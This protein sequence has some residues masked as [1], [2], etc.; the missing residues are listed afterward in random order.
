MRFYSYSNFLPSVLPCVWFET[1]WPLYI[2][3][4]VCAASWTWKCSFLRT[5]ARSHWMHLNVSTYVR[6]GF[7][8]AKHYAGISFVK[9]WGSSE[10][11]AELDRDQSMFLWWTLSVHYRLRLL[12]LYIDGLLH[13]FSISSALAFGILHSC[14]KPWIY[15]MS[16]LCFQ[17]FKRM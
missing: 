11:F 10:A 6:D 14:T 13:D 3:Y 5:H 12:I 15:W 4:N 17:L 9:M 2:K 1:A 7:V 16:L 8:F